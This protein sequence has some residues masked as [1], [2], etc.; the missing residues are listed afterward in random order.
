VQGVLASR[1]E[2]IPCI[3][4]PHNMRL[5]LKVNR[6]RLWERIL[7]QKVFPLADLTLFPSC[8]TAMDFLHAGWVDFRKVRVSQNG[9]DCAHFQPSGDGDAL[10][11]VGRLSS[12]KG[13]E[14]L[15]K[16]VRRL[17]TFFPKLRCIVA[18]GGHGTLSPELEHIGSVEDIREVYRQA[19]IYVSTSWVEGLSV[20]LLEAQ[21]MGIPA[22]VRRIGS[23]SEVI[24]HRLNGILAQSEEE[25]VAACTELLEDADL[26]R[27]MG[28][29]A[30]A[31]TLARF[32]IE[33]QVDEMES[34]HDEFS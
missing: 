3:A 12:E 27:S 33:K 18:G 16:V 29:S 13:F 5:I 24:E 8:T 6:N 34:V 31:A 23:N 10:V 22:V 11:A 17:Q 32:S 9:V 1:V 30:R 14:F 25:Y 7:I 20:A 26:R 15:G 28:A 19:A 21:A 2:N 4:F